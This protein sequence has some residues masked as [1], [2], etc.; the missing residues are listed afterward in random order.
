MTQW[1]SFSRLKIS[2][3]SPVF[4]LDLSRVC[5]VLESSKHVRTKAPSYSR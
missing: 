4:H 3:S 5:P 1:S 2:S